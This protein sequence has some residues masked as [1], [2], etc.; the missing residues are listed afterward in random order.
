[1]SINYDPLWDEQGELRHGC[2]VGEALTWLTGCGGHSV[3][4][5][6]SINGEA[7]KI[8]RLLYDP[9]RKKLHRSISA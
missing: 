7:Y 5:I 1:M 4:E 3:G 9:R 6:V 2:T 8:G